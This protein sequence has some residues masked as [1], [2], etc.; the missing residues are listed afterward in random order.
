MKT[1][2]GTVVALM[3]LC[4]AVMWSCNEVEDPKTDGDSDVD[5]VDTADATDQA[6]DADMADDTEND[7]VSDVDTD[8]TEIDGDDAD[9]PDPDPEPE[10]EPDVEPVDVEENLCVDD[11]WEPNDTLAEAAALTD[12]EN[13]DSLMADNDD[14]FS[15]NVCA[16]GLLT[17]TVSPQEDGAGMQTELLDEDETQLDSADNATGNRN[18]SHTATADITVYIH[19]SPAMDNA[20]AAYSLSWQV[21]GCDAVDG[22]VDTDGDIEQ[23]PNFCDPDPCNGH[24][25]CNPA[26]GACTCEAAYDGAACDQCSDGHIQYPQCLADSDGDGI[27]DENDNCPGVANDQQENNDNDAQGDA[28][29]TDDDNDGTPDETDCAPFDADV[30]P[31]AAELC[32]GLDNNCNDQTD[33]GFDDTDLDGEAD[34]VDPDDDN[35]NRNDDVD[36]CPT[37]PNP[38]QANIDNDALGDACDDDKDGDSVAND[39]DNCP[40]LPNADQLNFD[41]DAMGDV[42]DPDDDNDNSPDTSD[43]NPFNP[44]VFPGA[45]DECDGLDNNCNNQI[46]EGYPDADNDGV[47]NCIDPDDDNDNYLDEQDC[48]PLNADIHPNAPEVCNGVDDNCNQQVDESFPDTDNDEQKNCVD[49]DDDNDGDPDETDCQPLNAAIGHNAVEACNGLDDNCNNLTDEGYPDYDSDLIADCVDPDMDADGFPNGSDCDPLNSLVNPGQTEICNGIDDNCNNETDEGFGDL[50]NDGQANCVDPDDDGDMVNDDTDNCP[51]VPNAGQEDLEMDGI[52]DA[53]D[54]CPFDAANDIDGDGV[55]GDVDN[56]PDTPNPDQI[57]ADADGTGDVCD[58]CPYDF[59]NDIDLDGV[60]GDMDNCIDTPNPDQ[61]DADDDGAGDI[62][63]VCPYDADD[64]LD[65]D[66]VCGDEDN[67]PDTPNPNQ[68]DSDPIALFNGDFELGAD[69]QNPTGWTLDD[70]YECTGDACGSTGSR[71]AEG[72]KTSDYYFSGNSSIWTFAW[73]DNNGAA[74]V[75]NNTKALMVTDS[76]DARG[77]SHITYWQHADDPQYLSGCGLY[78]DANYYTEVRFRGTA[79]ESIPHPVYSSGTNRPCSSNVNLNVA[80]NQTATGDD[81]RT[82]YRYTVE[83]PLAYRNGPI[84]IGLGTFIRN[85]SGFIR[86]ARAY[87]DNVYLSDAGGNPYTATGDGIGDACDNCPGASNYS[88]TDSDNDGLGDACDRCLPGACEPHGS[89]INETGVCE[90]EAG[91]GGEDCTSWI[92]IP[93]PN[94]CAGNG[95][96]DDS[97]GVCTCDPGWTGDDCGT[98]TGFP[99]PNDCTGH[100][101]CDDVI[102][103]CTCDPGWSGSDCSIW[104]GIACPNDCS[105]NG[106]CDDLTG[107]CTCDPGWSGDDCGTWTG[108]PCPNDCSGNGFCDDTT[109]IC[110]CYPGWSGID[111]SRPENTGCPNDCSGHGI[112]TTSGYCLCEPDY[113]GPDCSLQVL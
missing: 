29:D 17:V 81:G 66:G 53:C 43:C 113:G 8:S 11:I 36:N 89:C 96:C 76:F 100:G 105:G 103:I 82:W 6:D 37:V 102:G 90:C 18:L 7:I 16:R 69:D 39:D 65:Q 93:C 88:Q 104:E 10:A 63:D 1:A 38:D 72:W 109:G 87:F 2:K 75:Y 111:C 5:Q 28:C 110:T 14:Y 77:A 34:C 98:W 59:D 92:G 20:C 91:W 51:L 31:G 64:D 84:T 68:S 42:C 106:F 112:C 35:D 23:T 79:G 62:C 24:G 50:D 22:D 83:I 41:G 97:I 56:C 33:E 70:V 48:A 15:V 71:R 95:Y 108:F 57:D 73:N 67:C 45:V 47:A 55:C 101:T 32:D 9:I 19:V 21:T 99:C 58:I 107:V 60:C 4:V 40:L 49:T 26:D 25:T 12:D 46:D 30:H 27:A 61:I 52:G 54:A 3:L 80:Y 85:Y 86:G 74:D 13:Y 44:A 78:H 94:D